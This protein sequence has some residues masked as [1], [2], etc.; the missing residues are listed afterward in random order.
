[1]TG[2]IGGWIAGAGARARLSGVPNTVAIRVTGPKHAGG[3]HLL[4]FDGERV[5]GQFIVW[6]NGSVEG[7]GIAVATGERAYFRDG[8][9]NDVAELDRLLDEFVI[10]LTKVEVPG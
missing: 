2:D 7:S 5:F 4:D 10:A 1:V 6:P 3:G 8:L 9:V